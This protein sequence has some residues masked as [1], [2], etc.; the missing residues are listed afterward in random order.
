LAQLHTHGHNPTWHR[1]L[2][3]AHTTT[4]P[5]YP[6]QHHRYWLTPTPTPDVS[7]AGLHQPDHPLLGAITT[8]A[9]QDQT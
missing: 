7:T 4:L 2:P 9:D 3:H 1:L 6:F 5:T 8:L